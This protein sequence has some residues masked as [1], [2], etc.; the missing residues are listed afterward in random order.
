MQRVP[1]RVL[2]LPSRHGAS[3]GAGPGTAVTGAVL[4]AAAARANCGGEEL[5][6]KCSVRL[7]G[8]RAAGLLGQKES[9]VYLQESQMLLEMNLFTGKQSWA[10]AGCVEPLLCAG[11]ALLL[12]MATATV[13]A[14]CVWGPQHRDPKPITGR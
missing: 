5:K 12:G 6:A 9:G 2:S 8:G 1:L 7:Q 11:A 3:H 10:V 4:A 13:S 14:L